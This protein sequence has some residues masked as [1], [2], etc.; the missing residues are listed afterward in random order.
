[1]N[2]VIVLGIRKGVGSGFGSFFVVQVNYFSGMDKALSML[3]LGVQKASDF[4][5][6]GQLFSFS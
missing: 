2:I 6:V 4:V 1:M 5:K 3:R